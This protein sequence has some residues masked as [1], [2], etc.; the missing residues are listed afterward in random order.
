VIY[1]AETPTGSIKIG[2][3]D[4]VEARL[5]GLA[6]YYGGPVSL[7]ATMP[8]D[9]E[10][11]REIHDRFASLRL[12]RTE[13]FRPGPDLMAF[14]GKPLLVDANPDAVEATS[15][16]RDVIVKVIKMRQEYADW[17]DRFATMERVSLASLFDRA[18]STHAARTGFEAPPERVP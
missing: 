17:L 6:S 7:L 2:C 12:G 9:R 15:P 10:R 16:V 11:E 5:Q 18:L 8:G 3:S 1:F 4:D 13:Q 14:I